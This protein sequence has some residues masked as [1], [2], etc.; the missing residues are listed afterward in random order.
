MGRTSG[1]SS[2][3]D[4]SSIAI[5]DVRP[6]IR[7]NGKSLA[8]SLPRA[9]ET[10]SRSGTMNDDLH[11][12]GTSYVELGLVDAVVTDSGVMS[13]FR[14]IPIVGCGVR[15][16]W[17]SWRRRS[18]GRSEH[19]WE[20][21]GR[22]RKGWLIELEGERGVD[23]S[24]SLILSSDTCLRADTESIQL[25]SC[26]GEGA[27]RRLSSRRNGQSPSLSS[28]FRLLSSPFRIRR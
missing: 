5:Q 19:G 28:T 8:T 27:G 15:A 4:S 20:N 10:S 16:E 14:R 21:K 25:M 1:D 22:G 24:A 26:E 18:R 2:Q 12:R 11:W 9:D 3:G 13:E 7:P 23:E 6:Q 17:T